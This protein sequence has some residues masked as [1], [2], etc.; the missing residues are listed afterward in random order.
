MKDVLAQADSM[1]SDRNDRGKGWVLIVDS[2]PPLILSVSQTE[3]RLRRR[4][5]RDTMVGC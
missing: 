1:L 4:I 3:D 2:G 5:H